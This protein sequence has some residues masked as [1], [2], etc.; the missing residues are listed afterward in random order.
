MGISAEAFGNHTKGIVN[1]AKDHNCTEWPS[2]KL[3]NDSLWLCD[4][5]FNVTKAWRCTPSSSSNNSDQTFLIYVRCERLKP[6]SK[7]NGT[8]I[9]G[10]NVIS[11]EP[12]RQ[13]TERKTIFTEYWIIFLYGAASGA[14]LLLFLV[15][16]LWVVY[17]RVKKRRKSKTLNDRAGVE[18]EWGLTEKL[19]SVTDQETTQPLRVDDEVVV[20]Q[21]EIEEDEYVTPVAVQAETQPA[22]QHNVAADETRTDGPVYAN[23]DGRSADVEGENDSDDQDKEDSTPFQ[24]GVV[25]YQNSAKS[26]YQDLKRIYENCMDGKVYMNLREQNKGSNTLPIQDD[27]KNGVSTEKGSTARPSSVAYVN[28]PKGRPK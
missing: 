8:G 7:S 19:V 24:K 25:H 22:S 4:D 28:L 11:K 12:T 13:P 1:Y 26:R 21:D 27:K 15:T 16:V 14:G 23:A 10:R 17:C 6:P 18:A 9:G 5:G 2:S 20:V 3:N